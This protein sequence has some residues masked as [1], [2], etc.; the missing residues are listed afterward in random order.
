MLRRYVIV[1]IVFFLLIGAYFVFFDKDE[2]EEY[3]DVYNK[4]VGFHNYKSSLNDITLSVDEINEDGKY[5]YIVTLD[6]IAMKM[7]NVKILVVPN[8]ATK[9]IIGSYPSFG[10]IDNKEYS[11]IPSDQQRGDKE[12]KGVNLMLI[13]GAKI[14]EL[15]IYFSSDSCEQLAKINVS[16]YLN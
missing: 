3:E 1:G 7:D 9:D 15:L 8:G 11:I 10:L 13:D 16:S 2:N 6:N 4:L 5:T 12:I 14:E